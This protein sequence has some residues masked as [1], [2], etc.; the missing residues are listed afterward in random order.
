MSKQIILI[1]LFYSLK[2]RLENNVFISLGFSDYCIQSR[3]KG[4]NGEY[5]LLMIVVKCTKSRENETGTP[6]S[7]HV[8]YS[9]GVLSKMITEL[10]FVN[11]VDDY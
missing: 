9:N 3:I 11:I 4:L 6:Q 1:L 5:P 10:D 7:Y 2:V 8:R